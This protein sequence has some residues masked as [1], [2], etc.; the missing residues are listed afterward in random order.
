MPAEFSPQIEQYIDGLEQLLTD[1]KGMVDGLEGLLGG[2]LLVEL[3]PDTV[4]EVDSLPLPDGAATQATLAA[5]L[6]KVIAAPSTEAKQDAANTLLT[7]IDGHVDGLEA[8]D[9]ATQTTLAAILAA[10]DGLEGFTDGVEGL[11]APLVMGD[12]GRKTSTSVGTAVVLAANTAAKF[13][14]V[15]ALR[16]NT[17]QVN[18]GGASALAVAGST[19]GDPLMAGDSTTFVVTNLNQVFLDVRVS[20]EGVTFTYWT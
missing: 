8:K 4:L 10:V 17:Q 6:A 15:T 13:V 16:T 7:A 11:L 12:S 20:G 9:F 19:A 14:R 3:E 2:T 5:L 18:V 1:L